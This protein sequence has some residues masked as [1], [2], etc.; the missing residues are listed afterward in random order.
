[1]NM[2]TFGEYAPYTEIDQPSKVTDLYG[3]A[4]VAFIR[5]VYTILSSKFLFDK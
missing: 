3:G 5:K 2:D 4:R 1:M